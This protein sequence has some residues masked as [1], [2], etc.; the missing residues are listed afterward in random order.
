MPPSLWY[1]TGMSGLT[2]RAAAMIEAGEYRYLSPVFRYDSETGEVLELLHVALTNTPALDGMDPVRLLA[3][4]SRL[5]PTRE[6]SQAM[7]EEQRFPLARRLVMKPYV[8]QV[9][10]GHRCSISWQASSPVGPL[11]VYRHPTR[12]MDTLHLPTQ[13]YRQYSLLL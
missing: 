12:I 5:Y 6:D 10:R 11:E 1:Q 2:D 4:A 13:M 8:S 7:N 9:C 3:A